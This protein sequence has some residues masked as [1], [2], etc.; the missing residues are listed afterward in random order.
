MSGEQREL[1]FRFLAE[2]ALKVMALS[3]DIEQAV[4]GLRQG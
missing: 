3:K 4:T 1:G 2:C